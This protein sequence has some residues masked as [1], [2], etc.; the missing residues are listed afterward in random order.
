MIARR[1]E[2]LQCIAKRHQKAIKAESWI[3]FRVNHQTVIGVKCHPGRDL[4]GNPFPAA[5]L[6]CYFS[7]H[8]VIIRFIFP[9]EA[10]LHIS[11]IIPNNH[12]QVIQFENSPL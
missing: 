4:L 11:T 6:E 2:S 8:S 12:Q 1:T 9:G 3:G 5:R 10:I 7:P